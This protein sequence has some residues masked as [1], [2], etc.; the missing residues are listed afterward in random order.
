M[1]CHYKLEVCTSYACTQLLHPERHV[2]PPMPLHQRRKYREMVRGMFIHAYDGYMSL[3]LPSAELGPQSCTPKSFGLTNI[4]L[5]TLIDSLDTL[6][7]MGNATEF[8]R[9][10]NIV[11]DQ[12]NFNLDANVSVFETTIRALGGLL[13]AH[14]LALR[15]DL[16][17]YN[18]SAPYHGGL[19]PLAH[20]LGGRLLPAFR[21]RS[22]IPYGTV[23]LRHGVPPKETTI[24]SLAGA[25]TLSIEFRLL[26]QL[27][28]DSQF[29]VVADGAVRA[30]FAE[31]NRRTG[32]VGTHINT[33]NSK[34]TESIAGI[35][36]NTDSYHEYL[37]KSHLLFDDTN[38]LQMFESS[39]KA[40]MTHIRQ[41]DWYGRS[42]MSSGKRQSA[43]AD[44]L[45]AF[46][47][48]LQIERYKL[49]HCHYD[50]CTSGR[51]LNA[52]YQAVR[53]FKFLPEEVEFRKWEPHSP[54]YLLRPELIESTMY[55][56]QLTGDS[57]W[58]I[59]V[60]GI[61]EDLEAN[62][63]TECGYATFS[64]MKT[65]TMEDSM[66]SFFLAETLKYLFLVFDDDNFI[67]QSEHV[68]TTEGHPV[69]VA[70]VRAY[71]GP[72]LP[73]VS[74]SHKKA[75]SQAFFCPKRTPKLCISSSYHP[76][77]TDQM[78][79]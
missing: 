25:G 79:A 59:A 9:A 33:A 58:L 15:S 55:M 1:N 65:S 32:L 23:N 36:S 75:L 2:P 61:L 18:G 31:R 34:W 13:S 57:S 16:G 68:F 28:G 27:T 63:R 42:E 60:A 76:H 48:G 40:V 24:A 52:F 46:W 70:Q 66:P 3:A 78:T 26:S 22:G 8:R 17:F 39:Y 10:V 53:E 44:G 35:G 49:H 77:F 5:L 38:S 41:G 14:L 21:T 7:V 4:G 47:P 71:R 43:I 64:N 11:T 73:P 37:L 45:T 19:L 12:A 54:K 72:T 67:H 51:T 50:L 29:G 69:S 56:Y 30:L 62:T 20:E 74:E 6:A